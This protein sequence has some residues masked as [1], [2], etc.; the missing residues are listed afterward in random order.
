MTPITG[1][2]LCLLVTLV[3][4]GLLGISLKLYTEVFKELS[5]RKRQHGDK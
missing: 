4:L 1:L 3:N 5:Q 2:Y